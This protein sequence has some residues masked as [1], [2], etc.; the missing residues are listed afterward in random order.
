MQVKIIGSMRSQFNEGDVLV[1]IKNIIT[2]DERD[3][4]NEPRKWTYKAGAFMSG[5]DVFGSQDFS[6]DYTFTVER[7]KPQLKVG[8]IMQGKRF[9][10]DLRCYHIET[11]VSKDDNR[12]LTVAHFI[13][14]D[15]LIITMQ[16]AV[17]DVALGQKELWFVD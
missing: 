6:S 9:A 1:K 2:R 17:I 7:F 10:G 3:F 15:G 14:V 5:N 4:S 13:N 11:L 16:V 8:S 12:E